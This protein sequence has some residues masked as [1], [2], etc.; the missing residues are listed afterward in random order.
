[1]AR[2][3]KEELA[4]L[5][6]SEPEVML[7]GKPRDFLVESHIVEATELGTKE[8]PAL[9]QHGSCMHD[10]DVMDPDTHRLLWQRVED[11]RDQHKDVSS[12][13]PLVITVRDFRCEA[14]AEA[15]ADILFADLTTFLKMTPDG[16][17]VERGVRSLWEENGFPG[18]FRQETYRSVAALLYRSHGKDWSLIGNPNAAIPVNPGVFPFARAII[19]KDEL[20]KWRRELL[21][22]PFGT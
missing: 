14:N 7:N 13:Y 11:K 9:A 20:T 21:A 17:V 12:T 10:L 1:M 2:P 16:T 5:L 22:N 4:E 15:A 18:V 8:C 3:L 6:S 19:S